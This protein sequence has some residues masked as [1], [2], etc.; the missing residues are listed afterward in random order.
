MNTGVFAIKSCKSK[1]TSMLQ[2]AMACPY[3]FDSQKSHS[4]CSQ[5]MLCGT[6]FFG[7]KRGTMW[8]CLVRNLLCRYC[9]IDS[10]DTCWLQYKVPGHSLRREACIQ[11][12][13]IMHP[14]HQ[15]QHHCMTNK[16]TYTW[17]VVWLH[18]ISVAPGLR[19]EDTYLC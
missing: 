15:Q 1:P 17:S 7:E 8:Y 10:S 11:L 19:H 2:G 13:S 12:S 18:C 3:F 14:A 6:V 4:L 9:Q 16:T 5:H